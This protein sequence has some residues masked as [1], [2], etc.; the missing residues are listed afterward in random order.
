VKKGDPLGNF[1]Y[2]GS[3]NILLFEK[4]V[5]TSVSV[6]MGSRLGTMSPSARSQ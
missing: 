3:L 2:G 4:G 1:A 5:F 6:L